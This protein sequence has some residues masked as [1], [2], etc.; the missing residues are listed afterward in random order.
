MN[1]TDFT[2]V[3]NAVLLYYEH[4]NSLFADHFIA[5][6]LGASSDAI[7]SKVGEWFHTSPEDLVTHLDPDNI[8]RVVSKTAAELREGKNAP[9][10]IRIIPMSDEEATD[11]GINLKIRYQFVDSV[12][13]RVLIASTVKGVCYLAFFDDSEDNAFG[14]LRARFPKAAYTE[15]GDAFQQN[16]LSFFN[17][18]K[19]PKEELALHLKGT[20]FQLNTWKKLLDIPWG[21]LMSYSALTTDI[22]DSHA[23][24]AAVGSNPIAYLIPCHR[25]VR[26]SGEFGAYHWGIARKA[27]LICLEAVVCKET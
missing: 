7:R 26:A 24:G 9:S 12:F 10:P 22:K 3:A 14:L 13:G 15:A 5:Q 8:Q 19:K 2:L 20:P 11:G 4:R 23:L 25:T 1:K 6:E 18:Q 27:A 21:G 17:Y 16:A